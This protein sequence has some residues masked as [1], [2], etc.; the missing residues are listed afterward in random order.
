AAELDRQTLAEWCGENVRTPI[1][2]ELIGLAGRTV[3]GAGPEEL[4]MLHALF[5]VSAAGSFDRLI[6]TEG[7]AQQDR[8]D[9]GAAGLALGP[10]ASLGER[11]RLDGPV[12]RIEQRDGAVRVVADGFAVDARRAIVAVPP[13]LAARIEF[14]PPLPE[15]RRRLAEQMKPG[16][17][18]KC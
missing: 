7:G 15:Q 10:A 6:D 4:S 14:G 12:R 13:V 8:L 17:L 3:W 2:R 18:N 9:G 5:Y 11:L 16:R 1:A